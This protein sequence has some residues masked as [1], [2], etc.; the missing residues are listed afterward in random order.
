MSKPHFLTESFASGEKMGIYGEKG[1]F[2]GE[3]FI[4][5]PKTLVR[6]M[7]RYAARSRETDGRERRR[8]DSRTPPS[9]GGAAGA[10]PSLLDQTGEVSEA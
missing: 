4:S 2:W 10:R 9:A 6:I 8:P 7:L 1:N 5:A 3:I